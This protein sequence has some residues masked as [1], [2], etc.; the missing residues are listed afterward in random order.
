MDRRGDRYGQCNLA[1]YDMKSERS[2]EVQLSSIKD[3]R[4]YDDSTPTTGLKPEQ[5]SG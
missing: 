4:W 2:D 3:E 5:H 1:G